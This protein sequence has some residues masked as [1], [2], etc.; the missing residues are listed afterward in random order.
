MR[1]GGAARCYPVFTPGDA[2]YE[3]G[4]ARSDPARFGYFGPAAGQ[5]R[6]VRQRMSVREPPGDRAFGRCGDQ[7]GRASHKKSCFFLPPAPDNGF[8]DLR[9]ARFT[10]PDLQEHNAMAYEF[11][12]AR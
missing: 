11:E 5:H 8:G 6:L 2:A 4:H 9:L 12:K 10:K 1:G 7:A 3:G